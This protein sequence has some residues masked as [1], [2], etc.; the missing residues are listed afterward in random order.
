MSWFPPGRTRCSSGGLSWLEII[1][2]PLRFLPEKSDRK[3]SSAPRIVEKM[4]SKVYH[5]SACHGRMEV[6]S[7]EKL[8]SGV[9]LECRTFLGQT[10]FVSIPERK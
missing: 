1:R 2:P 5:I 7:T 8:R 10:V 3:F 9:V 6:V 4:K